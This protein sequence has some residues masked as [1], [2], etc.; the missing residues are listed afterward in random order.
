LLDP[1][2]S[3]LEIHKLMYFLKATGEPLEKLQFEQGRYGPY[4]PTLRHGLTRMEGHYTRGYGTGADDP[5]TP[6]ELLPGAV[7]E[8]G[9]FL[10]GR[11]DTEGRME[12]VA[13]LIE[14][15]EDA[16]GLELLSSLHWVMQRDPAARENVEAA[17]AAVQA[18]NER[19]RQVLKPEHLRKA[20]TRLKEQGWHELLAA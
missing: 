4:S 10:A 6:I 2:V 16:Y 11:A 12:R 15:F 7:D 3:L 19:K 5:T 20:W 14:G 8:A 13:K 18:W 9:D 17:I 1:F